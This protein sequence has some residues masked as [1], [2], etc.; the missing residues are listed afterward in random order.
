MADG[1][2]QQPAIAIGHVFF[3]APDVAATAQW[4][5]RLG[6]KLIACD[7]AY[8]LLELRGGTHLVVTP[9]AR[10]PSRAGGEAPF[11]LMVDNIYTAHRDCT[12]K[13]L[14][15][16]SIRRDTVH[17]EFRLTGPDGCGVTVLCLNEGRG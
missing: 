15:P 5:E 12:A 8:A 13:G 10:R 4:L 11:D 3:A 14:V 17:D 16:S 2:D 9:T 7:E 1:R 6:L